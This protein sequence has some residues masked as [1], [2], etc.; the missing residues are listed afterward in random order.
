MKQTS[1]PR[2]TP[3]AGVF[4]LDAGL[5]IDDLGDFVV[6][7]LLSSPK[8]DAARRDLLRAKCEKHPKGRANSKRLTTE[9]SCFKDIDF[10][11][12]NVKL[13]RHN[14]FLFNF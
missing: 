12:P 1:I 5:R 2:S 9:E 7:V 13:S 3:E 14:A 6:E 11:P 10:V 8:G 4:S